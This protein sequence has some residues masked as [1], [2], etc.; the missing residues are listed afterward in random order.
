[1]EGGAFTF[2]GG[3]AVDGE[4]VT[5]FDEL[6]HLWAFGDGLDIAAHFAVV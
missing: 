1:M 4:E 2:F 3:F 6:A 5:L